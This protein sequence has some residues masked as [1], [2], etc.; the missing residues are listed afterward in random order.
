[1]PLVFGLISA[2]FGAMPVYW[3]GALMLGIG[4][5][6]MHGDASRRSHAPAAHPPH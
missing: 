5:W 4:G 6:L 3:L 2:A 1:M